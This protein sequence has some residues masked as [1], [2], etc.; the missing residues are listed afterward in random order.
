MKRAL[1]VAGVL[2]LVVLLLMQL[3]GPGEASG[4]TTPPK[5]PVPAC[6]ATVTAARTLAVTHRYTPAMRP[7]LGEEDSALVSAILA[8]PTQDAATAL[9]RQACLSWKLDFGMCLALDLVPLPCASDLVTW[10]ITGVEDYTVR[11][12]IR[13]RTGETIP[14]RGPKAVLCLYPTN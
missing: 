11:G 2:A 3:T 10:R 7:V 12:E 13:C 8:H 6:Q 4:A 5:T 14:M 1:T 9:A